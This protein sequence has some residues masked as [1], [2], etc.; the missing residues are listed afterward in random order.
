[1]ARPGKSKVFQTRM[2]TA[3]KALQGA[4]SLLL[5]SI[6]FTYAAGLCCGLIYWRW[7]HPLVLA[8][9]AAAKR[10][11]WPEVAAVT[12]AGLV[13]LVGLAWAAVVTA[14][15][16]RVLGSQALGRWSGA[17][18]VGAS[19]KPAA[20]VAVL[21]AKAKP[22]SKPRKRRRHGRA[23]GLAYA[24]SGLFRELVSGSQG[25]ASAISRSK[26]SSG[27]PCGL[28]TKV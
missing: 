5:A 4:E 19:A 1:M 3:L 18:L 12:K 11:D 6:K 26:S 21:V 22:K 2:N 7:L 25:L 15:Q 16:L 8:M 10:I 23:G 9:V 28:I 17:L 20:P 14:H 24:R 27:S 13:A